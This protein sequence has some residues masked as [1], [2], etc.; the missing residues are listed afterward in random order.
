MISF[1]FACAVITSAV[2]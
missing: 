1:I 2:L